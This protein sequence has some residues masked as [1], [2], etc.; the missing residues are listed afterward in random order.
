MRAVNVILSA[1]F[2][3]LALRYANNGD[4]ARTL[5]SL[6]FL[7]WCFS[8]MRNNVSRWLR[9]ENK[10]PRNCDNCKHRFVKEMGDIMKD[11]EELEKWKAK[12]EK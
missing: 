9:D 10:G 11:Y 3:A 6:F 1:V 12:N 5:L 8:E 7:Y 2:L 4:V